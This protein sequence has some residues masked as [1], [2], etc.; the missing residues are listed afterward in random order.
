[1][2]QITRQDGI[3]YYGSRRCETS[4]EAYLRFRNDYHKSIGRVS[5]KRLNRLGSRKE[6]VHGFGFVFKTVPDFSDITPKKIPVYL[7]GIMAGAY[8][9]CM[10]GE[11][12][13]DGTD[14][15]IEHWI[16]W[17]FCSETKA[18]R[19]VG[20]K[21]KTGRTSKRLKTRFR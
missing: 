6:R 1:M 20:K 7:L 9:K 12:I 2:E 15:E 13:P 17:A 5:F 11:Y 8:C 18:L 4:D 19:L 10:S 3:I 16:D 21:Q 14:E